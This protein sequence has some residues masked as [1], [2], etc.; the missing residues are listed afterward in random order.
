MELLVCW[1]VLGTK[2]CR[3]TGSQF[4]EILAILGYDTHADLVSDS[5]TILLHDYN[6]DSITEAIISRLLCCVFSDAQPEQFGTFLSALCLAFK[7]VER[8][9]V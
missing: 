6:F 5:Q 1:T 4:P 8:P 2:D 7:L 3:I 9:Y